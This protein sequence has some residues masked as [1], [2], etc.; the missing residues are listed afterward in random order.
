MDMTDVV[1][2]CDSITKSMTN[3]HP[4]TD[5]LGFADASVVVLCCTTTLA[6]WSVGTFTKYPNFSLSTQL[7]Y[8]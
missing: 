2:Y 5:F 3:C 7:H 8:I 1:M 6:P 4:L